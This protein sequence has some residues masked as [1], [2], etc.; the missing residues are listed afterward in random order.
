MLQQSKLIAL[1]LAIAMP[2]QAAADLSNKIYFF[3]LD[4]NTSRNIL[5]KSS[6]DQY[7]AEAPVS[8]FLRGAKSDVNKGS[9]RK[10]S[11]EFQPVSQ[12][13]VFEKGLLAEKPLAFLMRPD[14]FTELKQKNKKIDQVYKPEFQGLKG[15]SDVYQNILLSRGAR[16]LL[17][18]TTIASASNRSVSEKLLQQMSP[19]FSAETIDSVRY[20]KVPKDM[21]AIMAVS[22]GLA[23][24]ALSGENSFRVLVDLYQEQYEPM[25][26]VS[27]SRDL[28]RY[29]AVVRQDLDPELLASLQKTFST[30]ESHPMGLHAIG[31][32]GLDGW[33]AIEKWQEKE[34]RGHD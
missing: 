34:G 11:I 30:M 2:F 27:R 33:T 25:K 8:K 21:D 20:L 29:I 9:Q 1:L 28:K 19:T 22:F 14:L 4:I 10:Q 26:V 7:L 16:D 18:N 15:N 31:I 5:L 13:D 23:D 12:I 24:F 32:I 6:F 3:G 17:P